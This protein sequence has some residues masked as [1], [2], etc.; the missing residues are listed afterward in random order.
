L[1]ELEKYLN[2][3]IGISNN[4]NLELLKLFFTKSQLADLSNRTIAVVGTNGKTSTVNFIH[5]LLKKNN[6]SSLMF[7]SPHLVEYTERIQSDKN[8]NLE[9]NLDLVKDF[10]EKNNTILGYFETLFLLASQ[11]FLDSELDYFV[12][13]AGIGGKLD[14]TS[15][16]QSQNVVL[17]S[18]GKDH[19]DLLGYTD[20]EVLNQK[21]YISSNIKNLFVGD[22]NP[23]L[24]NLILNNYPHSKVKYFLSDFINNLN[25]EMS[26]LSANQKNYLLALNTVSLLLEININNEVNNLGTIEGR[27]EI[28]N[29]NPLKVLDGAHNL[30]GIKHF[31]K[32]YENQFNYE[33]TDVFVGFKKGKDLESIISYIKSKNKYSI[34][35]IQENSFYDQENSSD[36]LEYF[37]KENIEYRV[38]S[39]EA[40]SSNKNP[41][42]LLGSLYLIGEYKKRKLV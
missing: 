30:D 29:Q 2:S 31:F 37:Q 34:Y 17:T 14:T 41:S 38:A 35:F 6:K 7:T 15:V 11:L 18:I 33:K 27:F 24:K 39:L 25:I 13:E 19:Q 4:K 1:K 3:K 10:E 9:S 42:I 16:I 5:Q 22:I 40:F 23:E 32:D 21:I 28:V 8:L 20:H 36:Y 26:D 12:S